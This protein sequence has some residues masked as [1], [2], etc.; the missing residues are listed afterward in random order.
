MMSGCN[1][2]SNSRFKEGFGGA[3]FETHA[4]EGNFADK[5]REGAGIRA[6]SLLPF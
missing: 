4:E 3:G 6:L 5:G 1:F 2:G